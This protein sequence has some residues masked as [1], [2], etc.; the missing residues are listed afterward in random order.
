MNLNIKIDVIIVCYGE[1]YVIQV[2]KNIMLQ[3]LSIRNIYSSC[4]NFL[5]LGIRIT[6]PGLMELGF[7]PKAS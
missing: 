4:L 7:F 2:I 1:N 5:G 6:V 3:Y